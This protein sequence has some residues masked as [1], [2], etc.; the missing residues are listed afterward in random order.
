MPPI[1]DL[2]FFKNKTHRFGILKIKKL[3][4]KT[5][6]DEFD[7]RSKVE[8]F[9]LLMFFDVTDHSNLGHLFF[10]KTRFP[11]LK[12]TYRYGPGMTWEFLEDI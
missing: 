6:S 5:I 10:Q 12:L 1:C 2:S 8:T 11:F 4:L 7:K 3:L 9:E